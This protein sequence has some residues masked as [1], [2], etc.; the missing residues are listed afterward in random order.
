MPSH[1]CTRFGEHAP[2]DFQGRPG[3]TDGLNG[4]E[5]VPFSRI[6]VVISFPGDA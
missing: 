6:E 3:Q 4:T 5:N 2:V 1:G